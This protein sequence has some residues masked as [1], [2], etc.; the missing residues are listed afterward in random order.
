M[1][2]VEDAIEWLRQTF[3]PKTVELPFVVE[4]PAYAV[5]VKNSLFDGLRADYRGFDEWFGK[6]AKEHGNCW[7]I[8]VGGQMAG[9][10]VHKGEA[11]AEAGIVSSGT[12]S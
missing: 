12:K 5:D 7:I 2:S 6:C 11:P 8:E 10:V 3:E 9:I 1:L 4:R